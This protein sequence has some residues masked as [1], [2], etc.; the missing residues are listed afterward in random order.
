[1][2]SL[3]LSPSRRSLARHL[4]RFL[5]DEGLSRAGERYCMRRMPKDR[6]RRRR[7]FSSLQITLAALGIGADRRPAGGRA[8]GREEDHVTHRV[9]GAAV[10]PFD[11]VAADAAAAVVVFDP[12]YPSRTLRRRRPKRRARAVGLSVWAKK[13]ISLHHGIRPRNALRALTFRVA[14]SERV[15]ELARPMR[16]MLPET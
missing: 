7:L 16:A 15:S 14:F 12:R 1:M 4:A 10:R 13:R 2:P 8:D 11:G 6:R 3:C 5:N 9:I